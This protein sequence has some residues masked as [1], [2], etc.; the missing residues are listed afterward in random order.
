MKGKQQLY[1]LAM[2]SLIEMIGG[3]LAILA[4]ISEARKRGELTTKQAYD[5]RE[6]VKQ[7]CQEQEGLTIKSDAISELDKKIYEAIRYYR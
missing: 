4:Q 3:E 1:R 2:L 6:V 5:L 7:A